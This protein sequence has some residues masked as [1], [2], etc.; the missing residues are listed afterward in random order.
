MILVDK[1]INKEH[2]PIPKT[3]K[4]KSNFLPILSA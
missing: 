2:I 1:A 4:T 3:V